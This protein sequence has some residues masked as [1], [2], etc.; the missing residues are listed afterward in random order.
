MENKD[1]QV[2]VD[3]LQAEGYTCVLVKEG[4]VYTAT[5]R[6]VKPLMQWLD[7][8]M[9]F[10][11]FCAADKVVGKAAAYLYVLM[12]IRA[13]YAGVISAPAVEVLRSSG[14]EACWQEQVDAIRNRTNTG[15]CPMEQ[16]VIGAKTPQQAKEQIAQTLIRL[17]GN[18]I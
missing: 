16:A 2:A 9:D 3:L 7:S 6:G 1:L 18:G 8:G 17:A 10:S 5:Q 15:F 13:L 12:G 14:I 4:Q 11:G